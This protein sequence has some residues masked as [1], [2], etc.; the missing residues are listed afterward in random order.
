VTV[1]LLVDMNLSPRWCGA[2]VSRGIDAVH[3]SQVGDGGA[4]DETIMRYARENRWV[5]LTQDLDFGVL[6]ALTHALGPSVVQ[7][8]T[9]DSLAARMVPYVVA[10]VTAHRKLL[11]AGALVTVDEVRSRVR[12]LP[13][14]R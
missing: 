14:K 2:L 4:P 9:N 3:W 8:R 13:L 1:K 5:V 7:L 10:A 6:L 11:Q 12:V